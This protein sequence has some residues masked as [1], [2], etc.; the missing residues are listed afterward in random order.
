MIDPDRLA[1]INTDISWAESIRDSNDPVTLP[2]Q[3]FR[4]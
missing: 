2:K 3:E 4:S 1:E